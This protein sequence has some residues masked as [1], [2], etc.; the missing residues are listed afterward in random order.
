[1]GTLLFVAESA[2]S[3]NPCSQLARLAETTKSTRFAMQSRTMA[4]WSKS[5]DASKKQGRGF[6]AAVTFQPQW[7]TDQVTDVP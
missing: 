2:S 3:L 6:N 4:E 1:M 7:T 5:S